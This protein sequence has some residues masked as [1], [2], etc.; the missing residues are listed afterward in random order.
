MPEAHIIQLL[1][2][3]FIAPLLPLKRLFQW[4]EGVWTGRERSFHTGEQG[5]SDAPRLAVLS[6]LIS[7]RSL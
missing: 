6:T 2:E 4:E 3:D 7:R 5:P 1:K